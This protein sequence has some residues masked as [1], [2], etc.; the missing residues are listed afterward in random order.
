MTENGTVAHKH[1]ETESQNLAVEKYRR[2]FLV[3][4]IAFIAVAGFAAW[5]W[6]RSP[7]N[8]MARGNQGPVA[9]NVGSETSQATTEPT[10]SAADAT[11]S[12]SD[13]PLAPIQ[14]SPQR[15]QS[16]GVKVGTVESKVIST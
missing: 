15:M 8:P 4:L 16:I 11:P 9:A 1:E 2:A 13:T 12:Q 7:F 5:L 14:L 3:V 10:A 6:W